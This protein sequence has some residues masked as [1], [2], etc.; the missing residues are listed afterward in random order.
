M[1]SSPDALT[2]TPRE[3]APTP[4]PATPTT[5]TPTQTGVPQAP[6]SEP[7]TPVFRSGRPIN[8][9]E[10]LEKD[11]ISST[12]EEGRAVQGSLGEP[13]LSASLGGPGYPTT[14]GRGLVGSILKGRYSRSSVQHTNFSIPGKKR[15]ASTS[16]TVTIA[17][18]GRS[19]GRVTGLPDRLDTGF[20]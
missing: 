11:S 20:C 16:P 1:D 4:T 2:Q 18:L 17:V 6:T 5:P 14:V 19:R 9:R 15:K 12:I 13:R 7:T 8:L 10:A 3:L